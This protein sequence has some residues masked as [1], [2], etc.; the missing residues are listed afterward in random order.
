MKYTKQTP[1]AFIISLLIVTVPL[2]LLQKYQG[3]GFA[4]Y[5]I[6]VIALGY[7]LINNSG[8]SASLNYLQA[9][10]KKG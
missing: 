7:I 8:I 9:Q 6:A 1:Q 3:G 5:Y 4:W 2:W 10:S